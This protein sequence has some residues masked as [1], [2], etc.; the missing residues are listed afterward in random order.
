MS[1]NRK[2]KVVSMVP[3]SVGLL[4]PQYRISRKFTSEGQVALIEEDALDE[5]MY[6][7]GIKNLFEDG[8]L[9]IDDKA[10]RI[11]YGFELPEEI[12]EEENEEA[13]KDIVVFTTAEMLSLLRRAPIEEFKEKIET[14]S[15]EQV[16]ILVDLCVKY[17]ISDYEKTQILRKLTG[18]NVLSMIQLD[19]T[20]EKDNEE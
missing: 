4:I 15:L 9:F 1:E 10:K 14:M 12:L 20:V 16:K 17:K 5:G 11:Q 7:G 2:I 8:I 13:N 6:E 19:E 18:K 3:F